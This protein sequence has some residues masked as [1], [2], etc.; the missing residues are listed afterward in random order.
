MRALKRD[1]SIKSPHNSDVTTQ[2]REGIETCLFI[3]C[4]AI[5][6]VTT[7]AREGIETSL[8]CRCVDFGHVTTQ[9][10]EGIDT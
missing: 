3:F 8:I 10:R 7:Q 2:A 6:D 9:A 5:F 1:N 4:V